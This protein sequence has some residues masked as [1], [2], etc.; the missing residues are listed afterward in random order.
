MATAEDTIE[1][2]EISYEHKME[3]VIP[4]CR[5]VT[6]DEKLEELKNRAK[7]HIDSAIIYAQKNGK[8]HITNIYGVRT[9]ITVNNFSFGEMNLLF[10]L[11]TEWGILK[12]EYEEKGYYFGSDHRK[13]RQVI[14]ISW[15]LADM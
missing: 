1:E 9:G 4:E 2:S 6:M 15:C 3:A 5:I 11:I 12:N 13:D 10:Y 8:S 7:R 14:S